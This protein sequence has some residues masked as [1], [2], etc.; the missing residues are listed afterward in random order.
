M[1]LTYGVNQILGI[2]TIAAD[3]AVVLIVAEML[4]PGAFPWL[5]TVVKKKA[6]W[7]AFSA[8]VIATLGSLTYSDIIGY[9]PCKLCWFQ[10][11]FMY[12]QVILLGIALFKKEKAILDYSLSLAVIGGIIAA[13]HYLLQVGVAPAVPCS[14]VG[15]SAAC[16]QRFV[17]QYGYITIPM[18]AVS[19]FA[20]IIV[21]LVMARMRKED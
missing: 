1:T 10:R 13:Y 21:S 17:L 16:S 6:L 9:E 5:R 4:F 7:I 19:A 18:M 14:A 11:I 2:L 3:I 20:L 12:P 15:Y 8:A